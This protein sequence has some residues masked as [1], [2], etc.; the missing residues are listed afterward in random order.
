[1]S[2]KQYTDWL[3]DAENTHRTLMQEAGFIAK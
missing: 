1:M 3:Q 2:G